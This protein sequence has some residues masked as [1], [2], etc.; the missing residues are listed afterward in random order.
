MQPFVIETEILWGVMQHSRQ[1]DYIP[2]DEPLENRNRILSTKTH[3][4]SI[5]QV[6][7]R[8]QDRKGSFDSTLYQGMMREGEEKNRVSVSS[9]YARYLF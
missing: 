5:H 4:R 8:K 9:S 3:F 6:A 7:D 2:G 1:P